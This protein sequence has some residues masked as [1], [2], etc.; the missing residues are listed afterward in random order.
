MWQTISC[1][2]LAGRRTSND[3]ILLLYCRRLAA[4]LPAPAVA[5]AAS[6]AIHR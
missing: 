4:V 6:T 5:V 1:H 3:A 2:C